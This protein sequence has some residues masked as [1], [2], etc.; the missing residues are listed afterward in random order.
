MDNSK[1]TKKNKKEHA[2]SNRRQWPR[3]GP[4]AVPFLKSVDF[5]Q[6]SEVRVVNISRGGILLET[7]VRLRP[8]MKIF[9]KLVTTEGVVKMEGH[10]LRSS[11]SSLKGTPRYQTAIAFVHPFHMLDDLSAALK[12]SEEENGL[13]SETNEPPILIT[14]AEVPVVQLDSG[15]I[16][17][18]ESPI[19]TVVAQDGISLQDM[20]K[21]NDW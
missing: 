9:L 1:S 18:E 19:L 14:D 16:I 6:G 21:L 20:F 13:S 15:D 11:I 8:Q 3:L 10:V 5:S 2:E 17:K 4:E 12:E 7:E